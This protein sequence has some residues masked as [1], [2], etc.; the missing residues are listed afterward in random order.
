MEIAKAVVPGKAGEENIKKGALAERYSAKAS[1][2]R[3]AIIL[4]ANW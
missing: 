2:S 3:L 4:S 1:E